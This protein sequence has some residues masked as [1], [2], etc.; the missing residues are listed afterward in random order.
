MLGLIFAYTDIISLVKS[1]IIFQ[2]IDSE[3]NEVVFV[4][5]TNITL[6][7]SFHGIGTTDVTVWIENPNGNRLAEYYQMMSANYTIARVTMDDGGVYTC[8]VSYTSVDGYI[9]TQIATLFVNVQDDYKPQC[10]RNGTV[11]QPY[12]PGD[13]LL[14]SCYCRRGDMNP[15]MWASQV[16]GTRTGTILTPKEEIETITGKN[17]IRVL[18]SDTDN[19][20]RYD[21][22]SSS[23]ER[24][25]IGP[26]AD[27]TSDVVINS[28]K[29]LATTEKSGE[30]GILG[31][32]TTKEITVTADETSVSNDADTNQ[33]D[34]SSSSNA[35]SII[36]GCLAGILAIVV[37]ILVI[38]ILKMRRD[39][40][41]DENRD[42]AKVYGNDKRVDY[43]A[44]FYNTA[45]QQSNVSTSNAGLDSYESMADND[46]PYEAPAVQ[47]TDATYSGK[48]YFNSD[49]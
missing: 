19:N 41:S 47:K 7:C 1:Q 27:S 39:Q 8:K 15:C 43:S 6:T 12:K 16:I 2:F 30:G 4:N 5:E 42:K 37:V 25:A 44:K 22:F 21:C 14:L 33:L 20:T 17:I 28:M 23:H 26:L 49:S 9:L 48:I 31:G 34:N 11:G 32:M 18:S 38:Y 24:C 45:S 29:K 3:I 13:W 46:R 36:T 35:V 40:T 10:F